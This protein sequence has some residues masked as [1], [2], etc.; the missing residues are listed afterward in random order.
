VQNATFAGKVVWV[1]GASSGIGEALCYALSNGGAKLVLSARRGDVLEKVRA[2]CE[3]PNDHFV[4]PLDMFDTDSFPAAVEQ[5]LERFGHVDVLFNGAGMSQRGTALETQSSVDRRLMDLN[6]FGPVALTKLVL[7]SMI[8]RRSGHIVVVSSL[9]GKF[10]VPGRAAYAGS[11]HAIHGYFNALR[12]EV[13]SHDI[14]VTIVCPG[15]IRTN[16]SMNALKGDGTPHAQMDQDIAAGLSPEKC[17][18]QIM[19]AIAQR[20]SEVYIA[21]KERFA[22]L[23]SRLTPRLFNRLARKKKLK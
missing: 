14:L 21:G 7:P 4:L 19:R 16:A 18:R 13:Y 22:V 5:V 10:S 12:A 8:G 23:V 9:L 2:A 15:F 17:A 20:R 6:Y 3:R 11:K 1:T